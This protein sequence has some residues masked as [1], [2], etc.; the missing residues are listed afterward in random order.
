METTNDRYVRVSVT[1]MFYGLFAAALIVTLYYIRDLAFIFLTAVVIAAFVE[2]G[3][4]Q[5]RK[6]GISRT[7][8]VI[9]IYFSIFGIFGALIYFTIPVLY[10][11]AEQLSSF[12]ATYLPLGTSTATATTTM[13][14]FFAHFQAFAQSASGSVFDFA[15]MIF[16]GVFNFV[17]LCILSFYLSLNERAIEIFLR[18]IT[19]AEQ[20]ERIVGLWKRTERKIGLWFQGQLLLA[21]IVGILL[22]VSL[23]VIGV[24]YALLLAVLAAV[25]EL[26]PFGIILAAIPAVALGFAGQGSMG[27]LV[28][29]G[30]Y[31]IVHE[32]ELNIISP[33]VV[34]K[35]VGVS[36]FAVILSI[37][38]GLELAGFWGMMLG[39]PVAVLLTEI[40]SDVRQRK[41]IMDMST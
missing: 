24:Q 39:I 22:Y 15:I 36:S 14:S 21:L 19:P 29:A 23:L 10:G 35:V 34:Q 37:L 8:S 2:S 18:L 17:V 26:I 6:A 27:A 7:L 41:G 3:V 5:L 30:V 4:R 13:S 40:A 31:L 9:F 32:L 33:L 12:I 1:S 25:M 11:Q 28:I 16:G 20:T 38:V